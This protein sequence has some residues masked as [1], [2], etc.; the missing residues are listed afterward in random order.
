M[1]KTRE[2][3][4]E[5]VEQYE[6]HKGGKSMEHMLP[7]AIHLIAVT[8]VTS[9]SAYID[10]RL[11]LY[12]PACRGTVLAGGKADGQRNRPQRVMRGH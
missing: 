12:G 3:Y 11:G 5:N 6:I 1:R 10:V 7:K 9:A 2:A 4:V 8:F